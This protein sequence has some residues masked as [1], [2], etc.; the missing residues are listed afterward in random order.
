[1]HFLPPVQSVQRMRLKQILK[2]LSSRRVFSLLEHL[3]ALDD[4]DESDDAILQILQNKTEYFWLLESNE[5]KQSLQSLGS[6]LARVLLR[7]YSYT[8]RHNSHFLKNSSPYIE[9]DKILWQIYIKDYLALKLDDKRHLFI[10]LKNY[11]DWSNVQKSLCD[12]EM[13]S[14][15]FF[16]LTEELLQE[17]GCPVAF[18]MESLKLVLFLNPRHGAAIVFYSRLIQNIGKPSIACDF[19]EKQVRGGM[20]HSEV[21]ENF[22]DAVVDESRYET[23]LVFAQ[24]LA[25]RDIAHLDSDF[26]LKLSNLLFSASLFEASLFYNVKAI[27]FG[28][29]QVKFMTSLART[30]LTMGEFALAQK[31]IDQY[32]LSEMII[33]FMID[34]SQLQLS[35]RFAALDSEYPLTDKCLVLPSSDIR[36][37]RSRI[38]LRKHGTHDTCILYP[39]GWGPY[40][41][42]IQEQKLKVQKVEVPPVDST[43]QEITKAVIFAG[44]NFELS[45]DW[46]R[47]LNPFQFT[48]LKKD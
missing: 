41:I 15:I 40:R 9:G 3:R 1:M 6:N 46:I 2:D 10:N 16:P 37:S 44:I 21:L 39:D 13:I 32:D 33:F 17:K 26:Y 22:L 20:I 35:Y 34:D 24:Q 7:H 30:L 27:A 11:L 14:K 42:L 36:K 5:L 48:N 12:N 19:L 38:E 29:Q 18:I 43:D 45:L 23:L 28:G 25:K 8:H 31:V 4:P 47:H